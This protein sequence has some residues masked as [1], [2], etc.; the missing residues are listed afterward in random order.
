MLSI[1]L[2][3]HALLALV[4]VQQKDLNQLNAPI[5]QEEE[6]LELIKGFLRFNKHVLNAVDMVRRLVS[7][8]ILVVVMVKYKLMK[9]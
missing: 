8:V 4:V 6:R 1:Q 7:H 2:I 3:N 5:V 9:M